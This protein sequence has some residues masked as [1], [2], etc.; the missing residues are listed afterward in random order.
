VW[1]L[2]IEYSELTKHMTFSQTVAVELAVVQYLWDRSEEFR[3]GLGTAGIPPGAA[4]LGLETR[5][6]PLGP[7]E[8]YSEP[9]QYSCPF[10]NRV[11]D[12]NAETTQSPDCT[13]SPPRRPA[14]YYSDLQ[15]ELARA[16]TSTA[17]LALEAF[18]LTHSQLAPETKKFL[19]EW[20]D[21]FDSQKSLED[22]LESFPT[23]SS[24]GPS[25]PDKP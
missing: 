24:N 18:L 3:A 22:W 2:L 13:Q 23:Q 6:S 5:T 11:R 1:Q 25:D 20:V 14:D 10:L 16:V 9:P 17:P 19:S 21:T 7:T 8:E 4:L 12:Q 15:V